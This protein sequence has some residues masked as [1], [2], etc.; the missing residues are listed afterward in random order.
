MCLFSKFPS[1]L[2]IADVGTRADQLLF[3]ATS[4]VSLARSLY[5][6]GGK[7]HVRIFMVLVDRDQSRYA[8]PIEDELQRGVRHYSSRKHQQVIISKKEST[9]KR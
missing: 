3:F 7:T 2:L 1:G 4:I 5:L 9:R 8:I 6:S